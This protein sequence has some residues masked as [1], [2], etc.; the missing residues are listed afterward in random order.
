MLEELPFF[1]SELLL[2]K[3]GSKSKILNSLIRYS[4]NR[5]S[6]AIEEL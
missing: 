6:V 5:K 1:L 3:I 4:L 2:D